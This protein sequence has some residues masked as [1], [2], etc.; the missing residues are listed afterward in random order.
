M[1]NVASS[2]LKPTTG[3]QPGEVGPRSLR[4]ALLGNPNTGKTTTFNRLSGLRHK[5]G[6]FP[7]T[8]Q[9]ARVGRISG[10]ETSPALELV[11]LPGAYSLELDQ[12]ESEICRRVLDGTLAPPGLEPGAP[13]VVCLVVDATNLGRNLLLVGEALRRRLPTVVALNMID[14]FRRRGLVVDIDKL[15]ERLGCRVVACSA[16]SGEGLAELR[17]ALA[18]AVV[19]NRTPPGTQEGLEKWADEIFALVAA[20]APADSKCVQCGY[21]MSGHAA[22]AKCPECGRAQATHS[23]A[24]TTDRLDRIFTHPVLGLLVFAAVMTGL[25]WVIFTLAR[26]PMDLID[27]GFSHLSDFIKAHMAE[28][29]LRD[30]LAD[31]IVR[32]VSATVIFLPQICLLFFLISL[33]EDTGYLARAAFVMDRML[34]PFGLPGHSFMPLLSSHA[35]ALPGIMACRAIPDKRDRLATILVAPFMSCSARI[36]VY[37]LITMV[38]F[39]ASPLRQALAFVG[40]YA[41]GLAA[42]LTTSLIFRR[43]I[44]RGKSR[45]M[46]LELPTYKRPSLLTASLTTYDRGLIFLKNAGTNIM[47]ILIVLWW[48]GAYPKIQPP[49]QIQELRE[50]A[51]AEEAKGLLSDADA[52]RNHAAALESEHAKRAKSE[53]FLGTI[54]RGIQPVLAPL[55]FDRQLSVG[56]LASFAAREVFVS[57]MAVVTVGEEDKEKEGVMEAVAQAKRDDGTPIFTTSTCWSLLI[58]YVLAMQCLPTLAVTAREAGGV[59]W[60]MLQLAWMSGLAYAAALLVYHALKAS[61]VA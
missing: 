2:Y 24:T 50:Q 19:P 16:R 52:D 5:T 35:C 18:K 25:F 33:L 1:D 45:P 56:I 48:L 60:A 8:T 43:T 39:P 57:T 12:S 30:L 42:A 54:G 59:K 49:P 27:A 41:L 6:N 14:L 3:E 11:D 55:G 28:G 36:P 61:G 4:V 15:S 47:C 21:D 17:L 38:L 26:L 23:I 40:C 31:G 46:A 44:L 9:E 22:A 10:D 20:P 29:V 34:R 51:S 58:Y 53:S 37:V 32:G 13:D 7:G